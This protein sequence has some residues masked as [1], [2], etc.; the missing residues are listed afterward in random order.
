M[1]DH[2]PMTL[3]EKIL[4]AHALDPK[5]SGVQAGDIVRIKVDWTIASELAWNGM[6]KTYSM[7]GRPPIHDRNRFYLA[8]DHTVDTVTL[9]HDPKA[10]KLTELSREFAREANLTQFYD[11]NETILHTRFYRG[12]VQ[13]GELVLGGRQSYEQSRWSRRLRHRTRRGRRRCRHGSWRIV[14]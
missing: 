13:P 8:V 14:D 4:Y 3:T 2:L 1:V 10:Q 6:D 7:L 9:Q 12:L 11:A 5:K